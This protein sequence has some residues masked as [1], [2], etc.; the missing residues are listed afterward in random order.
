[1][2]RDEV[3]RIMK[4]V[5]DGKLSPD[6][7]TELIEAFEVSS[8]ESE[9]RE[10]SFAGTAGGS[11]PPPPPKVD[12]SDAKSDREPFAHFFEAIEKIGKDVATSVNWTEVAGQIRT[13]AKKGV[14]ALKQAA[15]EARKNGVHIGFGLFG[16]VS[17]RRVELPLTLPEGKSLRIDSPA[18]DIKVLGGQ[19]QAMAIAKATVRGANDEE[20]K[21]KA[22]SYTL[23]IEESDTSVLIR[24][25]DVTGLHV[26][27]EIHV[28]NSP[29]VEIRS[30]SGDIWV[31]GTGGAC[32]IQSESGDLHLVGLTKSAELQTTNGDVLLRDSATDYVEL[33]T[34][35]G[36]VR[37]EQV[38]GNLNVR[39][40]SG[41]INL[42]KCWGK[43]ISVEAV[44]GD[45]LID[46]DQP[47]TGTLTVHTVQG[48]TNVNV[49]DG[50]NCR[51]SIGTLRG[52]VSCGLEL[53]N[54]KSQ[55][56]RVTGILGQGE[57][58]LDISAISGD[59]RLG[60]RVHAP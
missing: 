29:D 4:L 53:E 20:A 18:G 58:Q 3:K 51:V 24:Q 50:S 6:D 12:G 11:P 40:S 27:L 28:T 19:P 56:Q 13:G 17:E 1:M 52:T 55:E 48:D 57:G 43:T 33:T 59:V 35:R 47:I 44:T 8:E 21:Q 25:P 16:S 34:E 14:E 5:Q 30:T 49:P 60:Q 38:T 22:D 37:L 54:A 2:N 42:S 10:P 45:V 36:S 15:E 26:D 9:E 39:T 41:D 32:R 7:A 23:I 46:L 31:E